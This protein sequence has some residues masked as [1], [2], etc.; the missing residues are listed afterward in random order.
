M[1]FQRTIPL[2]EPGHRYR[3]LVGFGWV[4]LPRNE[5]ELIGDQRVSDQEIADILNKGHEANRLILRVEP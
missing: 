1:K 5:P 3:M 4:Q 2:F